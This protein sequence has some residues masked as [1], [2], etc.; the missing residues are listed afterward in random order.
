MEKSHQ[1]IEFLLNNQRVELCDT[2]PST[3]LLSYLRGLVDKKGTKEG[4]ASGDCGACTV[5]LA[6]PDS[7]GLK[8]VAVNACIALL[9]AVHGK[10]VITIEAL[11]EKGKLHAAQQAMVDNH[12][13]QC[14][15]CT[16]GFVMSL[17][18]LGKSYPPLSGDGNSLEPINSLERI[19]SPEPINNREKILEALSGNLCRCT[20]YR[21]I[22]DA[23]E[24]YLTGLKDQNKALD[25]FDLV[26]NE[27]RDK[28]ITI[29]ELH[30][31]R[32]STK[33]LPHQPKLLP[34]SIDQLADQMMAHPDA[35]LLSGGTDLALLLT[36]NLQHLSP[37]IYLG[38]VAELK[39]MS[40][41]ETTFIIGAG[42]TY[43]ECF[44]QIN[45]AYP[46]WGEMILR[47]GSLQV[48]NHG[49]IGG[50]IGNASPIGDMPPVLIA[51][52]SKIEMRQGTQER[53]MLVEDYFVDYKVTSQK[54]SEF[55][56]SIHIPKPRT[57]FH[58]KI[59][60]VSKRF[61]DDISAVLAV[62]Y[63]RI[64]KGR[65]SEIAVVMGGMAAIPKRAICCEAALLGKTWSQDTIDNAKAALSEDYQPLSDMRA[66][67]EY[68][69]G[70]AKN[71]LQKCFIEIS[72]PELK[73]HVLNEVGVV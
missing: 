14:G 15:F 4:C 61:D 29:R 39:E 52:G 12:G 17:F 56:K 67:A 51:L 68:R 7:S 35:V 36:Q 25:Q 1:T 53:L 22:V 57:N 34:T 58:L 23:S 46:E 18:A 45:L 3:T 27:T 71:L 65:V 47:L 33:S 19:N 11:R 8:Y 44:T 60:K 49:T 30:L 54:K 24:Q 73:L 10:Q 69:M 31:D 64:E 37:L 72:Q 40:E 28:L 62:F 5:V 55:I 41:S 2:D 20:G 59:Y 50:N 38:K 9:P 32:N 42:V 70:L 21:S 66:S 26:Q 48:R 16:P 13:S 43:S 63:L 6:E